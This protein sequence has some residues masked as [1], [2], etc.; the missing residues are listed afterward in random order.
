MIIGNFGFNRRQIIVLFIAL[1]AGNVGFLAGSA[2][3]NMGWTGTS[4]VTT[5]QLSEAVLPLHHHELIAS[6]D[7]EH[8]ITVDW[9]S[10]YQAGRKRI[11]KVSWRVP[12]ADERDVHANVLPGMTFNRDG[13]AV[14]RVTVVFSVSDS[15][16]S[17]MR[18][19]MDADGSYKTARGL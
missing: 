10:S 12:I 18:V 7:R 2:I 5:L 16:D 6:P 9:D 13:S 17:P 19:E 15:V 14:D 3:E 8:H 1:S 4:H 11:S